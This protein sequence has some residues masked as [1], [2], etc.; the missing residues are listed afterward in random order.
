MKRMDFTKEKLPPIYIRDGRE[1]YLDPI[2]QKLIFITPEETVRQQVIQYLINRLHVPKEMIRIEEPLLHYGV[3][4]RNRADIIVEKYNKDNNELNPLVVIEC[5]APYIALSDNVISQMIG[6]SDALYCPFC[7]M[8]NGQQ[9]ECFYYNNDKQKY[10]SVVE[11]LEYIKMIKE[12]YTELEIADQL[13]RLSLEEIEQDTHVYDADLGLNTP[14]ELKKIC[15]NLWECLLYTEHR[16]PIKKYK[17]FE[18]IEDYGV[19]ILSYGNASGGLF[20][21][22]YRSFLIKYNNS[23]EFVSIGLSSYS[24]WAHIDVSKTAINVA[25]DNEESSHHALQLSMEDNVIIEKNKTHFY[26][27]GRIGISNKGSGKISELKDFLRNKTP[28]ILK[29]E[30]IYLGT[31]TYDR[32]WWLDDEE[33]AN[34][35]ENLITYV[36]IRDEYR[37]IVKH[38]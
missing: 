27:S 30:K 29:D 9:S 3:K 17:C 34:L 38:R 11:L 33:V 25:I 23:T 26:H 24:T 6:Y 10:V 13:P 35:I 21:G 36:L 28:W 5:K 1:C 4:S 8:T 14:D 31:L 2:R 16:F 15:I 12:E 7:V 18:L 19:R 37:E 20:Q 32:L 22:A